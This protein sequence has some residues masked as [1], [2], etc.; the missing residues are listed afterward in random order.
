LGGYT[1]K[2]FQLDFSGAVLKANTYH[3][4]TN[5]D[6]SEV[7]I[8]ER[9]VYD[10]QFRVK[11]H[12][13]QVNGNAE[14]LLSD[15]TYND[16]GQ[17]INKKVGN[18]L[19]S[20]DY[21]YNIRGL[22][23]KVNNPDNLGTDL[24]GYELKF[25][26][27]SNASVAQA[28][29]NGN[30]TEMIWKDSAEGTLKKY[31][32][33]YDA[34]N[35]LTAALYQE[36]NST[37][38]QNNFFN[39]TMNYD[40][41]GNIMGLKRNQKGY[42]GFVE[43]IDELAYSYNGNRLTSVV[44]YKNNYSG[45][46]NT[47]NNT[48]SYDFNGNMTNHVDKGILEIKYNDL[49]LPSY[50]KFNHFVNRNGQD[51]YKNLKYSYRADGVKTK[52]T[53]QYFS[54][55]LQAETIA[56]TEYIDGFQYDNQQFGFIGSNALKFFGTSEGYYDY[57]NNRYIYQYID[58]LGNVRVN[59]V[60]ENNV[61]TIVDKNDYYAFG[62][63]HG[64]NTFSFGEI[65]KYNYKYNNKELQEETGMYDYGARFYMPDLGRWGV[66]DP[67]AEQ[68][69]RHSPYN[70]AFNNPMRFI[71]P[72]GRR[73]EAGQSGIYYDW[74]M[75]QY[76]DSSTGGLSNF[77]AAMSYHSSSNGGSPISY[78]LAFFGGGTGGG[79]A[80]PKPTFWQ[81]VKSFFRNLFGGGES[82]QSNVVPIAGTAGVLTVGEVSKVG[83]ALTF[84]ETVAVLGNIL[85][86]ST[87]TL[88]LMLNGD[89][90]FAPNSIPYTPT[91]DVPITTT[92]E[93]E[94]TI[95]LYRGVH[96][97]H[98][99]LTN[100]YLGM[101]IPWGGNA[102]AYQHNMGDNNS[103]YT[104]WSKSIDVANW[105]ASRRGPG[106]VILKQS[107]SP[108]RLTNFNNYPGEQEMQVF[109]PVVGAQ[110]IKPWGKPG[111]WTPYIK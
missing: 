51:I 102:T 3:K 37:V 56:V 6:P 79:G 100:A 109:G 68:M 60:K 62:L 78:S 103:M 57:V 88:P 87:W 32:Y 16:L 9:F 50:I 5:T 92:S 96:S 25:A 77:D 107:F 75:E 90:D 10:D 61:A 69:R 23:T 67:L 17:V 72:D 106:G 52:K 82:Q 2:E 111:N 97:Q 41:N 58:H 20:I 19:Q 27:T 66:V 18:N 47:T 43:E 48:I 91:A 73:P 94:P 49:D 63:R 81:D 36:P 80:D 104:S 34:Y 35:R 108:L 38:P 13:H 93:P 101:A 33:Q 54:G 1:N 76:I 84:E 28:N 59:F 83:V 22:I 12:Y 44:D 29:Y 30:I 95:T 53:H 8:K 14:E 105:C 26:S 64:G 99:D 42:N 46:P 4:K 7:V 98:P 55:K 40:A 45:Y 31:S 70:Y 85:G 110:V 21:T 71:D 89:S 24:F 65:S 86:R 39:E 11:Q 74:D 15:Y